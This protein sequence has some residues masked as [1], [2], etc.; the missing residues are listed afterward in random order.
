MTQPTRDL[1]AFTGSGYE[2][3]RGKLWQIAWLVVS[4]TVFMRWWLP[5][6]ARVHIL[7]FFGAHIGT[8]VLIRHRV[9]IHWPWKLT[10]LDNSWIGEGA[11]LLNLE[12]ITI[13]RNVC[14]SQEVLLCTG[15]HD[16]RSPTFEF[17]NGP[18]T[19]ED[20][21]WV[22]T[23]ATVLRGLTVGAGSTVGA[24]ALVSAPVPPLATVLGP[25]DKGSLVLMQAS[26]P[27]TAVVITKN[28]SA[29]VG[30]C[31]RSLSFCDQVIVVDS[32]STDDTVDIARE[33]GAEIVNFSWN[34]RYPKKKQWGMSHPL[35]RNEWVLHMDADE[36]VDPTLALEICEAVATVSNHAVKAFDIPLEYHFS[37][38]PLRHGHRVKKRALVNRMYAAFP[39]VGDLDAPGITEVEG[40]Y[41]P[42]VRGRIGSLTRCLIHDDP[43]PLSDW[44]AR[45]NRYSDWEAYL[46]EHKDLRHRVRGNRS[47]GGRVFDQLPF[48]GLTFFLYSYVIRGGFLDGRAGFDYAFALA[49][50]Y[51]SIGAKH[52]EM[53]R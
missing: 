48:K 7:R 51:W 38:K 2:I 26:C 53:R 16:R 4:G 6:S 27:V 22:A 15:S 23:R 41:Q 50:Y 19:I 28:E 1:S 36:V 31:L 40:H 52:R 17:D 3:G 5:A 20:G 29:A 42:F 32:N 11:W 34:G 46:R 10:V 12:P 47:R 49:F 37:G 43:D 33:L 13:G 24:T 8:N 30:S 21:A 25:C 39:E 44:V 18:I 35:V 9:R 45:H 14:I